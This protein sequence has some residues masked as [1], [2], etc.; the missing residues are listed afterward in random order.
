M[1]IY[2]LD[3]LILRQYDKFSVWSQRKYNCS[4]YNLV[5]TCDNITSLGLSAA[6]TYMVIFGL[7]T[8]SAYNLF[9]GGIYAAAGAI[10]YEYSKKRNK[11]LEESE[12]AQIINSE[13]Q[14]APSLKIGRLLWLVMGVFGA[15]FGLSSLI[16]GADLPAEFFNISPDLEIPSLI[17]VR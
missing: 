3:E 13:A 4:K 9:N 6:G 17:N 14:I 16:Y 2:S 10:Y 5:Q 8:G 7:N 12:L 11:R 1:D 15:S